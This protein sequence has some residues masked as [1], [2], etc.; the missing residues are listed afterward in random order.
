MEVEMSIK[1]WETQPCLGLLYRYWKLRLRK[2]KKIAETT[3]N[4]LWFQR[5]FHAGGGT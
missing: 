1:S 2:A 4:S 5:F 3:G